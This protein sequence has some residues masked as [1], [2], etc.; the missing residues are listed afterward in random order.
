MTE[1][2]TGLFRRSGEP[3]LWMY[4]EV[5]LTALFTASGFI[6]VKR[7]TATSSRIADFASYQ[8]DSTETSLDRKPDSLYMEAIKSS[9]PDC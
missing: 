5:S 7:M 2:D 9:S 8:L 6:S 3:H 4:D 1:L